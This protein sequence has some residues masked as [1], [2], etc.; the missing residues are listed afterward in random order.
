ME[1]DAEL[2]DTATESLDRVVG[3]QVRFSQ[4]EQVKEE[5]AKV[6]MTIIDLARLVPAKNVSFLV[7][8]G[9]RKTLTGK[10]EWKKVQKKEGGQNL[11]LKKYNTIFRLS[12]FASFL[13]LGPFGGFQHYEGR[14][15]W[16][17]T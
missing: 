3:E 17:D 2:E 14:S 16:V 11:R 4:T 9:V 7:A 1:S 12:T 13:T 15:L 5:K 8:S 10:L 6:N